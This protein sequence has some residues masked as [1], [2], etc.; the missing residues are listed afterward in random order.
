MQRTTDATAAQQDSTTLL[1]LFPLTV[2]GE[3][4]VFNSADNFTLGAMADSAYE[5]LPKMAAMIGRAA[6]GLSDHVG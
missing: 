5:Y 3:K 1:G 6:A 2:D 4:M